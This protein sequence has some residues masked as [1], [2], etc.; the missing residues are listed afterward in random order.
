[1]REEQ[2][3]VSFPLESEDGLP[4][5]FHAD[6]GPAVLLRLDHERVA[7]RADLRLGAV[8]ELAYRVVVMHEHH[9]PRA[10]ACPGPLQ[11]LLIAIRVT[12]R[13][14]RAAADVRVDAD[15][16]A[17]L[18]VNK[19]HLRQPHEDGLAVAH[20]KL[21]F[22][23][24]ADDLLRRNGVALVGETRMNSTPPPETMKVLK[25]FAHR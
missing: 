20:F 11:H 3:L 23:A 1:M 14:D 9:Q 22:A 2:T 24:A 17:S 15:W 13:G 12:E 25:P 4:V 16:F 7:E 18:V 6:D 21:Q 10:I 19:V 5:V 8:G